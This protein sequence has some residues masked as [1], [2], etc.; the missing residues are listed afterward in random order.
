MASE[1][2]V[3]VKEAAELLGINQQA[4]RERMLRGLLPIGIVVKCTDKATK[5]PYTYHIYKEWLDRFLK[6][7]PVTIPEGISDI[8]PGRGRDD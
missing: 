8:D 5:R 6:G 4:I 3:T 2:T 1:N 7:D